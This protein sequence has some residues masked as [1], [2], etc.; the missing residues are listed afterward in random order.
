MSA[1]DN[2]EVLSPS[3]DELEDD[4]PSVSLMDLLVWLGDGKRWVAAAT[5]TAAVGAVAVALLLPN[6]YTARTTLL[7]PGSQ[8]QS[9]SAA[10]LAAL[11]SLGGLAGGISAKTPDE[12]YVSLLKS[13]S[14]QRALASR[15]NLMQRYEAKSYESLRK[16]MA[17]NIHVTSDKKSG[18]LTV[19]VDDKE[20]QFS[21]DLA[22]A[23]AAEVTRLLGRLA[24]SEAQQ[25]R[26]FFEQQ[27]KDTKENLIQAEQS[28]R[29]VQEKSGMVVLDKQAEAIITGVAQ[30]KAQIAERE[31]RLRVLRTG[32]T[33]ENPDVQRLNSELAG[34]RAELARMETASPGAATGSIDIPVGKLPAAAV[35]YIRARREVKFQE[36]LLESM[37]RQFEI[38]KLDEAKEGPSLQQVD[39]AQKPDRKSKPARAVIVLATT[40]LAFIAASMFVVWRRY[41]ALVNAQD[42]SRA[43][44]WQAI[45]QAWRWRRA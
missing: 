10:A 13:D 38:A 41:R 15:F 18:V 29:A 26:V 36:T 23:H 28:L 4:G 27:L 40:L 42:P 1:I 8:Q 33:S 37:L 12:L 2:P 25:R 43:A 44:A 45:R 17:A 5:A 35:D 14:V 22:N 32:A 24:V 21:A 20:P 7:A 34:L 31:V 3:L 9:S 16:E 30:L 11:G 19:E 39:I 6:L